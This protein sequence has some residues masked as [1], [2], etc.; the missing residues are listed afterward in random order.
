MFESEATTLVPGDSNG[1]TDVFAADLVS[2]ELSRVSTTA[3][4]EQADGHTWRTWR[5]SLTTDGRYVAFTS[6]ATNLTSRDLK[7]AAGLYVYDRKK[8]RTTLINVSPTGTVPEAGMGGHLSEIGDDGTRVAVFAWGLVPGSD[9]MLAVADLAHGTMLG[10]TPPEP[11]AGYGNIAF[12][13]DGSTYA[14]VSTSSNGVGNA[15]TNRVFA[16]TVDT[17]T[18]EHVSLPL[19]GTAPDAF[20]E[21]PVLSGNGR[22]VAYVSP[23]TNLAAG[24]TGGQRAMLLYDRDTHLTSRVSLDDDETPLVVADAWRRAAISRNGQVVAFA[25]PASATEHHAR[26]RALPR[27]RADRRPDRTGGQR[28]VVRASDAERQRPAGG[29]RGRRRRGFR[30]LHLRSGGRHGRARALPTRSISPI[31]F[32]VISADGQHLVFVSF[33]TNIVDRDTNEAPDIFVLDLQATKAIESVWPP[34][35]DDSGPT[36]ITISGS[37]FLGAVPAGALGANAVP[38]VPVSSISRPT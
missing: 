10:I 12:S 28:V 3:A 6:D 23:A 8:G 1:L 2:G 35:F 13:G 4:G 5:P 31:E 34:A 26:L 9:T 20:I 37:G 32:P 29:V 30:R 17:K 24:V 25:S 15:P 22:R 36:R 33:A 7:A 14:F 27:D 11:G 19:S 18:C 21:G 16:C 38:V